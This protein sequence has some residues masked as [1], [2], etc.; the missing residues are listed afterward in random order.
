MWPELDFSGF[1]ELHNKDNGKYKVGQVVVYI[2]PKDYKPFPGDW[3]IDYMGGE[4]EVRA[5][6]VCDKDEIEYLL[7]GFPY[8]VWE[9]EIESIE[10]ANK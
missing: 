10:N 7:A 9:E 2:G 1:E 3:R 6:N 5:V 4:F 8:L